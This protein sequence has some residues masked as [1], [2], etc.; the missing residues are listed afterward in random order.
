M[1]AAWFRAV[2]RSRCPKRPV[3]SKVMPSGVAV[4]GRLVN[5]V[6]ASEIQE[7][8]TQLPDQDGPAHLWRQAADL[9]SG[10][11]KEQVQRPEDLEVYFAELDILIRRQLWGSSY[12]L[13]DTIEK[14]LQRWN[15]AALLL[16]YRETVAGKL[17]VSYREMV[18]YNALGCIYLS[19]G[20]FGEARRH[21][22]TRCETQVL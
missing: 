18:N 14:K 16:K 21:S 12:E 17:R 3:V 22:I 1:V 19:R 13:I 7:A 8:L 5:R 20:N 11:R 4:A 6:P 10:S 15:A 9:L 2:T